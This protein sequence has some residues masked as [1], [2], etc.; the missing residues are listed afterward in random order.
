MQPFLALIL[1][2]PSSQFP[3]LIRTLTKETPVDFLFIDANE[4]DENT[5]RYTT[6]ENLLQEIQVI[7]GDYST[8]L[9]IGK[10]TEEIFQQQCPDIFQKKRLNFSLIDPPSKKLWCQK[11]NNLDLLRYFFIKGYSIYINEI[12][13][14]FKG[15]TFAEFTLLTDLICLKNED[16]L[17]EMLQ[18]EA[19]FCFPKKPPSLD[20]YAFIKSQE[21]PQTEAFIE[22]LENPHQDLAKRTIPV[23]TLIKPM[24]HLWV[25]TKPFATAGSLDYDLQKLLK[26][27]RHRKEEV[28]YCS[29]SP[30]AHLS[31]HL[32]SFMDNFEPDNELELEFNLDTIQHDIEAFAKT[33]GL[34]TLGER[35]SKT[36]RIILL[37]VE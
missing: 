34:Q 9:L 16:Q 4:T 33:K 1:G 10:R 20:S 15:L 31:D 36:S 28:K 17:D 21:T 7:M 24:L 3:E 2:N 27:T 6:S 29:F 26:E 37:K 23:F 19:L 11:E 35:S 32:F 5:F 12:L 22:I 25:Y 13:Q 18:R 30:K 14:K 8:L